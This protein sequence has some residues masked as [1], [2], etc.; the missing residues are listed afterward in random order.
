M[1]QID[2]VYSNRGIGQIRQEPRQPA[3]APESSSPGR[4]D[5]VDISE[6]AQ[7]LSRM[8]GLP[9]IRQDKVEQVRQAILQGNYET[10]DKFDVVADKILEELTQ[11]L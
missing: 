11:G 2:G 1:T 6:A 3:A 9:D 7:L 10:P 4:Q 5:Q 8:S